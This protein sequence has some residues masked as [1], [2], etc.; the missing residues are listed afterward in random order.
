MDAY[1]GIRKHPTALKEG[2]E[3]GQKVTGILEK[4][5]ARAP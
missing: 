5:K 1:G 4:L 3:K 2:F